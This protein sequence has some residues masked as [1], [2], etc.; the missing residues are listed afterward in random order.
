MPFDTKNKITTMAMPITTML[1][2]NTILPCL[3]RFSSMVISVGSGLAFGSGSTFVLLMKSTALTKFISFSF[4]NGECLANFTKSAV[5]N[6][7][8]YSRIDSLS[9][10]SNNLSIISAEVI[11]IA[12]NPNRSAI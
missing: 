10:V 12:L 6:K 2:N 9:L 7:Y 11:S 4:I 5:S 1:P 3:E 8:F